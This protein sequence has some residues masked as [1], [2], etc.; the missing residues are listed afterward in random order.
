MTEATITW[1]RLDV[2][3]RETA[4]L[5][6]SSHG[7]RLAGSATFTEPERQSALE[8][9]IDCDPDWRTRSCRVSGTVGQRSIDVN[10]AVD[11]DGRWVVNGVECLAVS[12]CV[13]IDLNFSPSTNLL[14][15]R[16]LQLAPGEEADVMAAW[17]RFPSFAFEA[18]PQRYRRLDQ[19]T[20]RYESA[21]G[22]FVR[23]LAV[24][25]A[26]FVTVYPGF[27]EVEE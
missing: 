25:D 11:A 19:N 26:G 16:R 1:R 8:Y 4:R 17:L 12:G 22:A 24:N 6:R 10:I 7:W 20:Y 15:I 27:W 13:D 5:G 18:L 14:P 3:G 21:G 23:E 2:P 9:V